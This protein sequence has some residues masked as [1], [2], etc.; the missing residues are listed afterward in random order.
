MCYMKSAKLLKAIA[1]TFL[2]AWKCSKKSFVAFFLYFFRIKLTI[3][4]FFCRNI[5]YLQLDDAEAYE[6][7]ITRICRNWAGKIELSVKK[8]F[9]FKLHGRFLYFI[10]NLL[11]CRVQL[12][13][14]TY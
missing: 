7:N 8:Y 4:T 2:C 5:K 3:L 9:I 10:F 1:Y 6:K 12:E 11:K 13:K 14:L